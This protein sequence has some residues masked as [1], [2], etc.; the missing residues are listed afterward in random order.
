MTLKE[1]ISFLEK[2]DKTKVVQFGFRNPH[3]YRGNYI[4]LAFESAKNITVREMLYH[5]KRSVGRAFPGYKDG[6]F[7]MNEDT[8]VHIAEYGKLGEKLNTKVL[9]GMMMTTA[10]TINEVL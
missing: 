4:H 9:E 6:K 8:H 1:V 10:N 2:E 3:S 5:A 7:R